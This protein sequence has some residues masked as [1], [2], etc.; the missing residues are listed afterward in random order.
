MMAKHEI[1]FKLNDFELTI[2]IKIVT[3]V[4]KALKLLK[5]KKDEKI[6]KEVDLLSIN[7]QLEEAHGKSDNETETETEGI[8]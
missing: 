7:Q 6:S 8:A 5:S 2:I 1:N 4:L 3:L